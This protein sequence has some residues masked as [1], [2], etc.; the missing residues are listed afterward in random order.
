MGRRA[1]LSRSEHVGYVMWNL[2]DQTFL[3]REGYDVSGIWEGRGKRVR[4][5]AG[6]GLFVHRFWC[7]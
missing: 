5:I 6:A 3:E 7:G 1:E 4:G 2:F